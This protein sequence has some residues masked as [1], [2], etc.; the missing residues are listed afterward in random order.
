M[1]RAAGTAFPTH[2]NACLCSLHLC[3]IKFR[4]KQ[5][6][7]RA[8]ASLSTG[9]IAFAA[10]KQKSV[11]NFL[12]RDEKIEKQLDEIGCRYRERMGEMNLSTGFLGSRKT[13]RDVMTT[14]LLT[15]SL[16]DTLR[17]ADDIM[18]LAK[19][20]HFPVLDQGRLVG[21]LD[22]A[23]LL[24]ASMR[25]LV[26][27]PGES[28]RHALG[29]VAVRD[30]MKPATTIRCDASLEEAACMMVDKQIDCLLVVNGDKLVGVA[31]RTD[32]LREMGGK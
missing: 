8:F 29:T 11:R 21:V 30:I 23:E 17:L 3:E 31:T 22:Q 25:S 7:A 24:H 19:L 12:I 1:P 6:N 18:N 9:G 13:V 5:R 27:H 2:A 4:P 28:L 20:R 10:L 14:E 32:L 16:D 26:R 15:L